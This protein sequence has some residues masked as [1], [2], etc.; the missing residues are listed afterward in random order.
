MRRDPDIEIEK[1]FL[2]ADLVQVGATVGVSVSLW[3]SS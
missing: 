3:L 1:R 2:S